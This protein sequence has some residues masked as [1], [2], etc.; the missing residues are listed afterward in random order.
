MGDGSNM[1]LKLC[2]KCKRPYLASKE[3]CP[4]CPEPYTWNQES[5]SN[6]GCLMLMLLPLFFLIFFWLFFFLSF[7]IR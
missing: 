2:P 5:Y 1:K 4:D 3:F 7:L 6:L